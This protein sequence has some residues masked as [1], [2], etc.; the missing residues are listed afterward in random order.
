MT[1]SDSYPNE[2][3]PTCH[4]GLPQTS[5]HLLLHCAQLSEARKKH[6]SNTINSLDGIFDS[7]QAPQIVK[8]LKETGLG[9]TR[10]IRDTDVDEEESVDYD[11]G[12]LGGR[13]PLDLDI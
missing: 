1:L 4:C 12:P 10:D 6:L 11:I 2:P 3:V 8:F 7:K 5:H 13:F 9:F